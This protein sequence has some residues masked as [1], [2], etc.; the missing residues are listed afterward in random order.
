MNNLNQLFKEKDLQESLREVNINL[1][2]KKIAEAS[3]TQ[4]EY[5]TFL[6]ELR[7]DINRIQ[8]NNEMLEDIY[9]KLDK[10]LKIEGQKKGQKYP[11]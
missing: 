9:E 7:S 4:F 11:L 6:E 5:N 10:N 8:A 2:K 1:L 3:K